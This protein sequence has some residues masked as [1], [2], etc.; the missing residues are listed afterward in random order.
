MKQQQQT[1]YY[2]NK[3]LYFFC[4]ILFL[5]K[6]Y[7]CWNLKKGNLSNFIQMDLYLLYDYIS[8]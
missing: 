4:Q 1:I 3:H 2:D 8:L 7:V 6:I 5:N